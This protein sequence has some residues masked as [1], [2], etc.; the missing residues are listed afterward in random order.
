MAKKSGFLDDRMPARLRHDGWQNVLTGVGVR[1]KDKRLGG[2]L[3]FDNVLTEQEVE[4][5]YAGDGQARRLV[6]I[7]PNTATRQWIKFNKPE[8]NAKQGSIAKEVKRLQIKA[9]VKECWQNARI[10]GGAG[11][12]LNTGDRPEDLVNPLDERNIRQFISI[13]PLT[14][15]E[16]QVR[17]T[18]INSDITSPNFNKPEFYH[19]AVRRGNTAALNYIPI[20]HSRIVRFDGLYLPR[21]LSYRNQMWGSDVFTPIHETLRDFGITHGSIANII[22]D[23]RILVYKIAGLSQIVDSEDIEKLKVRLEA[24][25]LTKSVLG[26][27]MLD[28]EEEMEYFSSPVAGLPEL[29]LRMKERLQA[30]VD[31]PHTILFNESPSGL[32]ATGRTEET[33]WYDQVKAEQETYLEPILDRIFKIMFL[34]KSGPT[35][36]REP[37]D[38]SYTFND[39]WQATAEEDAK[40]GKLRAETSAIYIDRD[41]MSNDEARKRDLPDLEG[42]APEPEEPP[43]PDDPNLIP[44][45]LTA[46][47]KN[48]PAE[49]AQGATGGAGK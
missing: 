2:S 39:L 12:F 19:L 36:G 44:G 43:V 18:D 13:I 5:I 46:A 26:A 8:L 16:M 10:Y 7:L 48:K 49:G 1:N 14:R 41:V 38:W 17:P 21:I 6:D 29:V 22:Q 11:G 42:P 24:M 37:A 4:D 25:N 45:Q 15:W 27:F 28:T 3:K 34:A 33:Q 31:I 20:H 32:G 47:G 35:S 30:C 40:I 9:R 23:F